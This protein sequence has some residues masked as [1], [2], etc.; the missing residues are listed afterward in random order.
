MLVID[1]ETQHNSSSLR[2]ERQSHED[3]IGRKLQFSA[4]EEGRPLSWASGGSGNGRYSLRS[5][6]AHAVAGRWCA[7]RE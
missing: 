1:A 7:S 3:R 5:P 6:S 4:H 2:A